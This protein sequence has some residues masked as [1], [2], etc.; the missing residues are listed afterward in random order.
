MGDDGDGTFLGSCHISINIEDA[1]RLEKFH[2][3][4]QEKE[5][6][7]GRKDGKRRRRSSK[8]KDENEDDFGGYSKLKFKVYCNA[9][10]AYLKYGK[11]YGDKIRKQELIDLQLIEKMKTEHQF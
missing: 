8:I 9:L 7:I 3:S 11:N 6:K 5:I 4:I 10:A 2:E 1:N